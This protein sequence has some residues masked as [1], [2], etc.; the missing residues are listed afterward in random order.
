MRNR[1][2]RGTGTDVRLLSLDFDPVYGDAARESFSG[3][4]SVFDFDVVIWD[5]EESY[6]SYQPQ[7]AYA[8]RYFQGFPWLDENTSVR[9][10]A[11]V[12]R[13]REE[14]DEFIGSGRVLIII[15]RGPQRCYVDTGK[16]TFSG[17]GRNRVT[18]NI[19]EG[20]DLLD[21]IPTDQIEFK[22]AAGD[23]IEIDGGG[24]LADLLKK[25]SARLKYDAIVTGATGT[26]IARVAGTDKTIGCVLRSDSGG[27]LVLLPRIALEAQFTSNDSDDDD[28]SDEPDDEYV[29][30]Y[31]DEAPEFQQDLIEAIQNLAGSREISRPAWMDR[32]TT[33]EQQTLRL[34]LTKQQSQVESARAR[35]A[36]LQQKIE[37]V[38]TKDQLFLGTGRSLE[39]EVRK[40]LELL[41]GK[42]TEPA[43]GRDDWKVHFPE[44][45]AVVEVKGVGKSAAEKHAA[46]L[47]KWVSMA[48]EAGADMAPKGILVV[49]TWKDKPLDERTGEDYPDQMMPYAKSRNHCLVTGL[50]LYVI[51]SEIESK[52][53]S[54]KEWRQKLL[55]TSGRVSGCD[56][57]RAVLRKVE[58]DEE[59]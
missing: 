7:S 45:D 26:T 49:N 35:L 58:L 10:R 57:W 3:D 6:K 55:S 53:T 29:D 13:R 21:A 47:E 4:R 39:L 8:K 16:R 9:V 43:P 1:T 25:Y 42:V 28:E 50:Q 22:V 36:R 56:N 30:E 17:T 34:R 14:F 5:P 41:G 51:R 31:V 18:T 20:F 19:L 2:E 32:Y 46:Q 44:G 33:D 27:Y 52:K 37:A 12:A 15:V 38:E 24:P 59:E 54:A 48:I 11:D 23:R 40:V